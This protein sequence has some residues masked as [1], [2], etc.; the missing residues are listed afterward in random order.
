MKG[1]KC[2]SLSSGKGRQAGRKNQIEPKIWMIPTLMVVIETYGGHSKRSI[3][4]RQTINKMVN[5][6]GLT[7]SISESMEA[8]ILPTNMQHFLITLSDPRRG[9][10]I[11]LKI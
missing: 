6:Q 7:S 5:D 1:I 8:Q 9:T 11:L 4:T 10:K 2:S 3:T